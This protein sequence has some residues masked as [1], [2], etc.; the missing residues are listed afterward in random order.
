MLRQTGRMRKSWALLAV[1]LLLAAGCARPVELTPAQAQERYAP[2]LD[3]VVTAVN[4]HMLPGPAT[5]AEATTQTMLDGSTCRI[6]VRRTAD[7]GNPERARFD[8]LRDALDPVIT[9]KGFGHKSDFSPTDR[10]S[11]RLTAK[12]GDGA[13][14]A[15]EVVSGGKAV[16][17]VVVAAPRSACGETSAR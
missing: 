11:S 13:E 16:V 3:E 5:W 6:V 15:M 9:A 17:E 10:G 4:P 7:G 1:P 12:D 8:A 14:F 2:L